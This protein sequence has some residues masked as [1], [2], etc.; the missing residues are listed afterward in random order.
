MRP[1]FA[2]RIVLYDPATE[3]APTFWNVMVHGLNS[4]AVLVEVLVTARPWRWHHFYQPAIAGLLS[5]LGAKQLFYNRTTYSIV[6]S[7]V[8]SLLKN[9]YNLIVRAIFIIVED[10]F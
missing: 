3:G 1:D 8:D 6:K 7:V 5:V 9:I 2:R 4:A 10:I